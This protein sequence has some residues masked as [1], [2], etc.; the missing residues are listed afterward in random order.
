[1][2]HVAVP[3]STFR[4]EFNVEINT[5]GHLQGKAKPEHPAEKWSSGTWRWHFQVLCRHHHPL[6]AQEEREESTGGKGEVVVQ[7]PIK[8]WFLLLIVHVCSGKHTL[9]QLD[10]LPPDTRSLLQQL[11][12]SA[13]GKP[14][15]THGMLE[16]CGT[17][18]PQK[19]SIKRK[20][21]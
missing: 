10:T 6:P 8:A 7:C 5:Q 11:W 4:S 1:M 12:L 3:F 19:R 18:C 13:A 21:K 16:T 20:G 2:H 14:L 15:Y 9:T 17:S